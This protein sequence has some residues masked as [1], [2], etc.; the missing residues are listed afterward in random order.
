MST[1]QI[2]KTDMTVPAG[3]EGILDPG[4]KILWQGRPDGQVAFKIGHI[5]TFIFGLFFAGFAVFWMVMASQAGGFFWMFGLIHFG[6]GVSLSIGPPF[7]SA[8]KRRHTWYSLTN[9][10]GFIATDTPFLRRKLA[11]YPITPDT[12]LGYTAGTPAT[13]HFAQESRRSKNGTYQVDIGFERI[14][15]GET[16]YRLMRDIQRG[17]L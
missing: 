14:D 4:E 3:W 7:Y 13:I 15:G 5:F 11:S 2:D 12:A 6:V 16:V 9:K 17:A 10:R 1:Q 8:W